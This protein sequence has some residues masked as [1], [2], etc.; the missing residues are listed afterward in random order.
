MNASRSFRELNIVDRPG[1]HPAFV[2]MHGFPDDCRIYDRLAPLLSPR[3]VVTFD[4]FGY[5]RSGR[6]SAHDAVFAP[7]NDLTTVMETLDLDRVVLVG[8]DASG[9]VAINYA[10]EDPERVV[11]LVLLDVLFGHSPSL[12]LPEM[13]RLFADPDLAPL[14]DA[15]IADPVQ[16]LW[17]LQFMSRQFFRTDETP[18][19]GLAATS[20]LP[21]FF[22]GD[23]MPDALVAIKE[24]TSSLFDDLTEHDRRIASGDLARLEVPVTLLSGSNDAYLGPDVARELAEH[25][26]S[27]DVQVVPDASHWPQW[28]KPEIVA[29]YLL[30]PR[31]H[32]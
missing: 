23:D 3:R 11:Q 16:R 17:L 18:P 32:E 28:D 7:K 30:A 9:A 12:R 20:I 2:T 31:A 29:E 5:G 8:H 25:F 19:D 1:V 24:W 6:A 13:I 22:G 26:T 27:A 14:V 15:M 21:Q 4:F 10:L